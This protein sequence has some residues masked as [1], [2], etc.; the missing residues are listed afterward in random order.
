M[1]PELLDLLQAA[2]V[3]A[4]VLTAVAA[5]RKSKP[6]AGKLG[7]EADLIRV[8]AQAKVIDSLQDELGRAQKYIRNL[9]Q[10]KDA[11]IAELRTTVCRLQR[12]VISLQTK[13]RTDP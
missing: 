12:Q 8:E 10:E 7:A 6:E 3:A 11:E 5:F 13:E 2:G 4:A 1:T 9:K